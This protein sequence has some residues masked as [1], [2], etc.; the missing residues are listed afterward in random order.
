MNNELITQKRSLKDNVSFNNCVLEGELKN[1]V[2][3]EE[4]RAKLLDSVA[5]QYHNW[6]GILRISVIPIQGVCSLRTGKC[7]CFLS[8]IWIM[9]LF[10]T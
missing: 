4:F 7:L 3:P 8:F 6:S 5:K 9:L 1:S 2:S 10:M